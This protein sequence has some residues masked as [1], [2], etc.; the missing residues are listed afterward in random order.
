MEF[1]CNT[2]KGKIKYG[3]FKVY[4][5][6]FHDNEYCLYQT[7]SKEEYNKLYDEENEEEL[8]YDNDLVY[9]SELEEGE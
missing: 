4:D 1:N 5:E 6:H 2:C 7:Y 3:Y 8:S 9:Y